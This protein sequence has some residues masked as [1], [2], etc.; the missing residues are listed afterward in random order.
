M[1][2]T[3]S[4]DS[5]VDLLVLGGG[6]TG[7]A[8]AYEASS[9]G[10]ETLLLEQNDF[11]SGT[12][13][14]TGKLIH[15]GLRYLKKFEFGLVRESLRERRILSKIA[16][17][18][19][20]PFPTI[21]PNPGIVERMGL[22][23]YD[24][25]SFDRNRGGNRQRLPGTRRI[26]G[27]A[28]RALAPN[29]LENPA[30]DVLRYFDCLCISPERLT[31]TFL[32]S[33]MNYGARAANY[34]EALRFLVKDN[35]VIGAIVKDKM[36]GKEHEV[37]ARTVVNATGPWTQTLLNRSLEQSVPDPQT[38]SEGIYLVTR[39]LS[40]EMYLFVGR[41]GHFSFA[42]WN[43][44][45]LI[46]PTDTPYHGEVSKWAVS[47]QSINRFLEVINAT[48]DLKTP[49][50]REDV[51]FAYGGLRPL[52]ETGEDTYNASRRSD[53]HDHAD[54][55]MEGLITAAGGKYTTS[56]HFAEEIF[57][58]VVKKVK[59]K[60]GPP[61]SEHQLLFGCS[62]NVEDEIQ[63]LRQWAGL[64]ERTADFLVR[65]Y[66]TEARSLVSE[67]HGPNALGP[68]NERGE[69]LAQVI[70][71]V[72]HEMAL[73]VD[74]VLFRRTDIGWFG[75]PGKELMDQII[76]IMGA[77]LG[78][79]AREANEQRNRAE[80]HYRFSDKPGDDLQ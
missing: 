36:S 32:K 47:E 43:N 53:L 50:R 41:H 3:A 37:R 5:E 29:S 31:L 44:H 30:S 78:W 54:D 67:A 14:A 52:A 75:H 55:G 12:S 39:K 27:E 13:A 45:S 26:K 38:R 6:I 63:E 79:S 69:I 70:F 22:M 46:G 9:R 28:A 58:R 19:V 35:R 2:R 49:L 25:L 72:R 10:Y 21:L 23:A 68:I 40:E 59:K 16:P 34:V 65:H 7:A 74:D 64:D 4:I 20:Y 66:G 57:S 15:G 51:L 42:P 61:L 60:A 24:L 1:D 8:L 62:E 73:N 48:A 77:E 18:F 80:G 11:G 76:D 17:N 71:A 33:A 56:R